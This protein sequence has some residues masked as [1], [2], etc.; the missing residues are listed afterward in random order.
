MINE[1]QEPMG[2]AL[3]D[4]NFPKHHTLPRKTRQRYPMQEVG[5]SQLL[6]FENALLVESWLAT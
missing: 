2:Y 1:G 4:I 6:S 3:G 5:H